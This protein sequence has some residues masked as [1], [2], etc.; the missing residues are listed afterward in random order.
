[1]KYCM[2]TMCIDS[3]SLTDKINAI[4]KAGFD[5][6]EMWIKDVD[7]QNQLLIKKQIEDSG[8]KVTEFVKLE[9]WFED[10]WSLMNT[11]HNHASIIGECKRRMEIAKDF[12]AEFIVAFPSRTDRGF[13]KSVEYGRDSYYELLCIGQEIGICPTLE[14][15]GQSGQINSLNST[16]D[17]IYG[18]DHPLAKIIIDSFHLWRSKGRLEDIYKV[19]KDMISLLHISD[20][21]T[22]YKVDEYKDRHR[23]MPGDGI[24]DLVGFIR[25]ARKIGFDGCVSLGCYNHDNWT[26]NPYDVAKEG[27]IKMR[28]VMGHPYFLIVPEAKKS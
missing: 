18:I 2:S 10:D 12:G 25:A 6:I 3:S 23:V 1:M 26:R 22:K 11:K 24:I 28:N 21:S 19:N 9:G 27:M 17:F 15:I 4:A 13:F 7:G 5:S 14:F 16:L 8:L 20:A